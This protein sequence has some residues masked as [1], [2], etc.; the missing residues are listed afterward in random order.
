MNTLQVAPVPVNPLTD[1][2]TNAH[3][4]SIANPSFAAVVAVPDKVIVPA[5]TKLTLLFDTAI[6][7]V[8]AKAP[9]DPFA[10][11]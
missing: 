4:A 3:A 6:V 10:T 8:A 1:A 5:V 11:A 9:A 2:R 7:T